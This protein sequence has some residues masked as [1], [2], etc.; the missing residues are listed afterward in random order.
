MV[1]DAIEAKDVL[2]VGKYNRIANGIGAADATRSTTAS[3]IS[4]IRLRQAP[5]GTFA[6]AKNVHGLA[7]ILVATATTSTLLLLLLPWIF[8]MHALTLYRAIVGALAAR[9]AKRSAHFTARWI[10]AGQKVAQLGKLVLA[11]LI[12]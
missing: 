12:D 7:S 11:A 1:A 5:G 2:A 4:G 6:S 3:G 10:V 9:A 8:P